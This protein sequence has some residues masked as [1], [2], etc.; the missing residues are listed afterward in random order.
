[1]NRFH[2]H[3]S[4]W[5]VGEAREPGIQ[6]HILNMHLDSGSGPSS[7]PGMTRRWRFSGEGATADRNNLPAF[8]NP[9][10]IMVGN[11]PSIMAREAGRV[12]SS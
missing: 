6:K 4:F 1:M 5:G 8:L 2:L 10:S 3:T 7:R 9:S 11:A 12:T